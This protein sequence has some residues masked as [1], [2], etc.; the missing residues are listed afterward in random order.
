MA[1]YNKDLIEVSFTG[2]VNITNQ[3]E[4]FCNRKESSEKLARIGKCTSESEM[5]QF[6]LPDTTKLEP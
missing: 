1:L 3:F 6:R 5:S 4:R 2:K